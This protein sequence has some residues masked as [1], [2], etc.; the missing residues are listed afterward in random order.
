M[1][2]SSV[3]P[4]ISNLNSLICLMSPPL[5]LSIFSHRLSGHPISSSHSRNLF[6]STACAKTILLSSISAFSCHTHLSFRCNL[7]HSLLYLRQS[8]MSFR[9]PFY[10]VTVALL[11]PFFF[12]ACLFYP[13]VIPPHLHNLSP[14]L[15]LS[16]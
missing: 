7:T 3:L 16:S 8:P 12:S 13:S 11:S 14:T 2:A 5:R 15:F 9:S 1:S 10:S 4:S 6:N